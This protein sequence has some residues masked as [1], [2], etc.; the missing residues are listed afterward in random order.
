[1]LNGAAAIGLAMLVLAGSFVASSSASH[2]REERLALFW[3]RYAAEY[4]ELHRGWDGIAPRLRS[5]AENYP[6]PEFE[7]VAIIGA[8]GQAVARFGG[9]ASAGAIVRKPIVEKGAIIGY[10]ETA[11]KSR[12]PLTPLVWLLA[13]AAGA[14]AFGIGM[15]QRARRVAE[16]REQSERLYERL[17]AL[18]PGLAAKASAA[19][20]EANGSLTR[21][22]K[23]EHTVRQ[24]EAYMGKLETV[25]RSMVADFAHELRTPLAVMR[26][27]LENTLN[28]GVPLPLAKAAAMHDETLHLSKLVHDLQEL[29]LAEAGKL[30]LEK[31]WLSL[32]SLTEA[33]TD[34][35]QAEAEER[36]VALS[37]QAEKDVSVYA[38]AARMRQLIVNLTGNALRHARKRVTIH[39]AQYEADVVWTVRDDG[40]GIDEEQLPSLF[41]RFYRGESYAPSGDSRRP[42][43]GLGLAIAKQYTEAHGGTITAASRWGEGASFQVKLPVI[44]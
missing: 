18:V 12:G 13:A 9:T 34:A 25:R 11:S 26:S 39:I 6:E 16:A 38:D 36:G 10:T 3:N 28:A 44:A 40:Y 42:G 43:L 2:G 23:L 24:V 15:L 41:E 14:A 30:P 19:A 7:S 1:M 4:Y 21:E 20:D 5:I 37:L 32:R 22:G 27:Q 29:A 17:A 33:V 31:R 35:L 8:D